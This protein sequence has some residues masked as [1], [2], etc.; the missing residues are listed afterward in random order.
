MRLSPPD[1]YAKHVT[2]MAWKGINYTQAQDDAF[3]DA[4]ST[5]E[6]MAQAHNSPHY[7]EGVIIGNRDVGGKPVTTYAWMVAEN[8]KDTHRD[9][10]YF[11]TAD[12]PEAIY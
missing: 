12:Q 7:A 4:I 3:S 8:I 9:C 1:A 6:Y 2:D 5:G 11:Q 10:N